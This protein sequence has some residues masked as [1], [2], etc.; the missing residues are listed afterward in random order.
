M[1]ASA[2]G[3]VARKTSSWQPKPE[4]F[5]KVGTAPIV[6]DVKAVATPVLRHRLV[7]NHRAIGDG[8]STDDIIDRLIKEIGN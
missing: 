1:S 2:P 4:H 7:G 5:S 3:H 8:V 6:A